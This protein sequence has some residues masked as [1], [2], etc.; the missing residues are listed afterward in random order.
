MDDISWYEYIAIFIGM[1]LKKRYAAGVSCVV[2]LIVLAI[3]G[4]VGLPAKIDSLIL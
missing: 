1:H 2:I 4:M 3:Y